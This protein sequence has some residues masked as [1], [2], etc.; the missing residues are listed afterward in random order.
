LKIAVSASGPTLD[1]SVDPCFG[2]APSFCS[3]TRTP[4]EF[5]A[6]PNPINLQ[7]AQGAGIQTATLVDRYKPQ[8]VLTGNCGQGLPGPE[9]RG[10]S[11]RS[12]VALGDHPA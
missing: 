2:R 7:A 1:A 8:A 9:G 6:V 5:E 10:H 3:L 12:G 4:W 11:G